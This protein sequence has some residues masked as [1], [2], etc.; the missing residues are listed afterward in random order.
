M[1][2]KH[3]YPILEFDDNKDAKIN[4]T[5]FVDSTFN[6]NKMII[7]FFPEVIDKLITDGRIVL[8]REIA[9]ENIVYVYRFV[10]AEVL[11][12]LGVV[13]C[14]SCA[15]NLDL[16]HAMGVTKVM[17]CGGGGV[18]DK[19]IK[20]GQLLVVEGAIRDE[21]FSFHYV[22]PS[23]YIYTD[24][25]VTEKMI[26][27]LEEKKISYLQGLTWTT[28][29]I[30]RETA[31]R[32][33]RRKAEGAKIVEMEQSGC[34]AVAQYRGFDYGALIYGGDDVSQEEWSNRAWRSREGI[35]Y[36]LVMLCK[37]LVNVI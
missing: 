1:F 37:D 26:R 12:T 30:F 28:D 25:K 32:I 11:I 4:P 15:G 19:N 17:F 14:P 24:K 9:G 2:T 5:T 34:I 6:C 16:F 21:G 10:D 8:D 23:R 36:D 33:A 20:V 7:T 13:G 29:A 35:R 22:K 27:Y 3:D 18:L 31:D